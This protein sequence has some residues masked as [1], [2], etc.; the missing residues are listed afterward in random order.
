MYL[1]IRVYCRQPN[2]GHHLALDHCYRHW[3]V[4]PPRRNDYAPSI[5]EGGIMRQLTQWE[6]IVIFGGCGLLFVVV[7]FFRLR[8]RNGHRGLKTMA[9]C[10]YWLILVGF[11]LI[12]TM[13]FTLGLL[14]LMIGSLGVLYEY[15]I[16]VKL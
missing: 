13:L 14:A 6:L 10:Y 2:S 3:I 9:I 16:G 11:Y 5:E 7:S 4:K 15:S 8:Y 1:G 12:A